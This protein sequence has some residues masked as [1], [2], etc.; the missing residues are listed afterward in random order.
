MDD[1]AD[2]LYFLH[3]V[4]PLRGCDYLGDEQLTAGRNRITQWTEEKLR[5]IGQDASPEQPATEATLADTGADDGL[6]DRMFYEVAT[7][8]CICATLSEWDLAGQPT[9]AKCRIGS[10]ELSLRQSIGRLHQLT[11]AVEDLKSKAARS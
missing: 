6:Y 4:E 11:A 9:D 7:L 10:A 8:E 5:A 3:N 1:V 2:V